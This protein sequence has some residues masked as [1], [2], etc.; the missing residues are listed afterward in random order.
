MED[1]YLFKAKARFDNIYCKK[2][3]WVVGHLIYKHF[4]PE[5][6]YMPVI[7]DMKGKYPKSCWV[8]EDTI[9]QCTGKKELNDKLIFENDC[10]EVCELDGR[11]DILLILYF[12]VW[13]SEEYCCW[14]AIEVDKEFK[15]IHRGLF[16]TLADVLNYDNFDKG[17]SWECEVIGNLFDEYEKK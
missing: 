3:E 16:M 10:L 6:A 1:R 15:D 17:I 4:Y 2:G 13:Y 14:Y 11:G 12:K 9:C 5:N 7:E 8:I